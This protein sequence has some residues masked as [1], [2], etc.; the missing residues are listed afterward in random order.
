MKTNL[1]AFKITFSDGDIIE[2]NMAKGTTLA[3][4]KEYYMSNKFVAADETTMRTAVKVEEITEYE[5]IRL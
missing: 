3:K 5:T 2:T 4:A 1:P